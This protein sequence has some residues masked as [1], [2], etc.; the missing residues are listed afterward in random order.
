M[1]ELLPA[2]EVAPCFREGEFRS[3]LEVAP[4][5]GEG[6]LRP[7]LEVVVARRSSPSLRGGGRATDDLQEVV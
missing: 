4:C 3:A 5:A 7:A 6:E 2:L 1:D